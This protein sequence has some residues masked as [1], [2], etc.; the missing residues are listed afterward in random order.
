LAEGVG[1]MKVGGVRKLIIPPELGY[2]SAQL[3]RIPPDSTLI[4]EVQLLKVRPPTPPA[5]QPASE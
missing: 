4:Y 2:G 3:P 1:T 5:T